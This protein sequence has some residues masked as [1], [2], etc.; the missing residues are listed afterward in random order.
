V[1]AQGAQLTPQVVCDL[2]EEAALARTLVHDNIVRA[3]GIVADHIGTPKAEC[4]VLLELCDESVYNMIHAPDA[5][6]KLSFEQRLDMALHLCMGLKFLHDMGIVHGDLKALNA[7]RLGDVYKLCDFGFSKTVAFISSVA[8]TST[9]AAHT[10]TPFWRAPEMFG[11]KVTH[12]HLSHLQRAHVFCLFRVWAGRRQ[13]TCTAAQN[14]HAVCFCN[15]LLMY[16]FGVTLW[17]IFSSHVPYD[18]EK[19]SAGEIIDELKDLLTDRDDPLRPDLDLVDPRVRPLL[20]VCAL[21]LN[22]RRF[23]FADS[24][25]LQPQRCWAMDPKDRISASDLFNELQ[26]LPRNASLTDLCT[27]VF[28]RLPILCSRNTVVSSMLY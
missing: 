21:A 20:Q 26:K 1:K 12:S 23:A 24:S 2:K 28:V 19:K 8:A 14:F 27:N 9:K 25:P 15:T 16:A 22:P 3:Y 6:A 7:L 11:R 4:G 17:E 5:R 18:T 13:P 10:G